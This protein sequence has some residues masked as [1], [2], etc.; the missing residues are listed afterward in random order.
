MAREAKYKEIEIQEEK[1]TVQQK[2]ALELRTIS[3]KIN[4]S[5]NLQLLD[6][7]QNDCIIRKSIGSEMFRSNPSYGFGWNIVDVL[8]K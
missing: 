8:M 5:S 7:I 3:N 6:I 1:K 4:K 2:R